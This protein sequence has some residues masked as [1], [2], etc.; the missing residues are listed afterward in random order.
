MK[1]EREEARKIE[2]MKAREEREREDE[3]E[4][5]LNELLERFHNGLFNA[6]EGDSIWCKTLKSLDQKGVYLLAIVGLLGKGEVE[7]KS[8]SDNVDVMVS[9]F[10]RL[11]A[12]FDLLVDIMGDSMLEWKDWQGRITLDYVTLRKL[13]YFFKILPLVVDEVYAAAG[14]TREEMDMF[15]KAVEEFAEDLDDDVDDEDDEDD[16]DEEDEDDDDE[17]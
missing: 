11:E 10:C 16:E 1:R 4:N 14:F 13:Y 9:K 8:F 12:F 15:D 3:H 6:D 2:A 5:K 17:E 7:K